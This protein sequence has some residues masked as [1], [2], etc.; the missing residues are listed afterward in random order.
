MKRKKLKI[1]YSYDMFSY[2]EIPCENKDKIKVG[3]SLY[4]KE[5]NI[6]FNCV[7]TNPLIFTNPITSDSHILMFILT[8]VK[9]NNYKFINLRKPDLNIMYNF[10]DERKW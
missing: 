10:N 7:C 4:Q 8:T 5:L 6:W 9:E 3:D 2:E 1:D